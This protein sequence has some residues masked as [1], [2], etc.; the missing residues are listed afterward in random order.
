[1][2]D[3]IK[4]D[5]DISQKENNLKTN[6]LKDF[7]EEAAKRNEVPLIHL[8]F[9][10]LVNNVYAD[11]HDNVVKLYE[12]DSSIL[13]DE[14]KEQLIERLKREYISESAETIEQ[15]VHKE[16]NKMFTWKER[17]NGEEKNHKDRYINNSNMNEDEFVHKII[18]YVLETMDLE[19]KRA[20]EISAE[21]LGIKYAL[22]N[23]LNEK[24][25]LPEELVGKYESGKDFKEKEKE[26]IKGLFKEVL[27]EGAQTPS[28]EKAL[29]SMLEKVILDKTAVQGNSFLNLE[30]VKKA[31]EDDLLSGLINPDATRY[32]K[33]WL[34]TVLKNTI[35]G[36]EQISSGNKLNT[37]YVFYDEEQKRTVFKTGTKVTDR[38]NDGK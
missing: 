23:A 3:L 2:K 10:D 9:L 38:E 24:Y 13:E 14:K 29:Q 37:E 30:E 19:R 6:I 36:S 15:L 35:K 16:I 33:D 20:T 4:E 12:K 8:G 5:I 31:I 11:I 17:S 7:K 28:E 22:I 1:M 21:R 34:R 18:E 32:S 25:D 26:R 27:S